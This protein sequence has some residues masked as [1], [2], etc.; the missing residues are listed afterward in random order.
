MLKLL[1][2]MPELQRWAEDS[3]ISKYIAV[4]HGSIEWIGGPLDPGFS[5]NFIKP[6]D[7]AWL[8]E[9]VRLSVV[10]DREGLLALAESAP[11][12]SAKLWCRNPPCCPAC[13]SVLP[14]HSEVCCRVVFSIGDE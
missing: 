10:G 8:I 14:H 12:D 3:V 9:L 4:H 13:G 11:T 6:E 1:E 5:M 2:Q 7:G